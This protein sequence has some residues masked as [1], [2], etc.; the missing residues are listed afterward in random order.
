MH[1]WTIFNS[2]P[3]F[4]FIAKSQFRGRN[5]EKHKKSLIWYWQFFY[6]LRE[7]YGIFYAV[8]DVFDAKGLFSHL[9][10]LYDGALFM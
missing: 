3:I 9:R 8:F 6:L 7:T 5:W 4:V 10:N 1:I 2:S